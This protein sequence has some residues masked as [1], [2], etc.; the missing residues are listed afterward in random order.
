MKVISLQSICNHFWTLLNFVESK[1]VTV[2]EKNFEMSTMQAFCWLQKTFSIWSQAWKYPEVTCICQSSA[3]LNDNVILQKSPNREKPF[4][5]GLYPS[6][7]EVENRTS[8][9][10]L[11]RTGLKVIQ[12]NHF[13][14]ADKTTQRSYWLHAFGANIGI[15][16]SRMTFQPIDI[17]AWQSENS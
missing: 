7:T 17:W 13:C 4:H 9:D 6:S 14:N 8:S 1:L 12:Y 11:G 2:V 15:K 16:K 3:E 10:S 5:L